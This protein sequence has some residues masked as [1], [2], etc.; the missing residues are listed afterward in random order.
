M[1]AVLGFVVLF[2][3]FSITANDANFLSARTSPIS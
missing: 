1:P 2:V 3:F